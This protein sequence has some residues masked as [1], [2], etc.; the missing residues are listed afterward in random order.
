MDDLTRNQHFV[1]QLLLRHFETSDEEV[2][3]FDSTRNKIRT[4]SIRRVF[5]R[6]KFYDDDNAVEKFLAEKVEG[7]AAEA[8]NSIVASPNQAIEPG[9]PALLT[10]I[11]VQM[12]RT[13]GTQTQALDFVDGFSSMVFEQFAELNG[14]P[15]ES[16]RNLKW[17]PTD[18]RVMR[19]RLLL[20]SVLNRWLL[21]DLSWHVLSNSTDLP[22]VISDH[23]AVPY[24]WYLRNSDDPSYTGMTKIGVQIFLPLSPSVTLALIDK[25]IYK[26]GE[27]GSGHTVLHDKRDVDLLNSLQFRSR[28]DFIVFPLAMDANYV[29]RSCVEIPA[30]SLVRACASRTDPVPTGD[31]KLSSSLCVWRT[32]A[33]YEQW[34]SVCKIKRRVSKMA[35]ECRDRRPETVAAQMAAARD[36]FDRSTN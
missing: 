22:F 12:A 4:S 5:S 3:I 32:Q 35:V 9:L 25:S 17:R 13:P 19:N 30:S 21:E 36:L 14:H 24:N 31:D 1:P 20:R 18:E 11:A 27:K 8:V 6:N 7:P 34:L 15:I 16:V 10:F 28:Q 26:F 2:Q 33:R 23:P 29:K